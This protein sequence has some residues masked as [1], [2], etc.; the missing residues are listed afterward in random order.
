MQYLSKN[1]EKVLKTIEDMKQSATE[2]ERTIMA[3]SLSG[4]D[5]D[6]IDIEN[7]LI[8]LHHV[9]ALNQDFLGLL[10]K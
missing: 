10:V 7:T 1:F 9:P 3:L 5:T 4:M 8:Y 2:E 6:K